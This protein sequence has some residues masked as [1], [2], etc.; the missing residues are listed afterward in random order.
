MRLK[1]TALVLACLLVTLSSLSYPQDSSSPGSIGVVIAQTYDKASDAHHGTWVILAVL[2]GSPA[3]HAGLRAGDTILAAGPVAA[4]GLSEDEFMKAL[5]GPPGVTVDLLIL[6]PFEALPLP[7]RNIRRVP[8]STLTRPPERDLQ[9][10]NLILQKFL[11]NN[12]IQGSNATSAHAK[13]PFP[14]ENFPALAG[15]PNTPASQ[16]T[17]NAQAPAA[18]A[19]P[20]TVAG[21]SPSPDTDFK[22]LLLADPSFVGTWV[23]ESA[24]AVDY[25]RIEVELRPDGTFTRTQTIRTPMFISSPSGGY[26]GSGPTTVLN[27]EGTWK[28]VDGEVVLSTHD[29]MRSLHKVP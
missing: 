12:S 17:T 3:Q 26:S 19:Q 28:V 14:S 27:K 25:N 18:S 2:D 24:S 23:S 9:T 10:V 8:S 15:V 4:T 11:A 13:L 6:R 5:A 1:P 29:D 22:Y 16:N 20:A 21:A 7:V